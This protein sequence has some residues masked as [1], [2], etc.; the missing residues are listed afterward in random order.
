MQLSAQLESTALAMVIIQSQSQSW[1]HVLQYYLPIIMA[2]CTA[3][4][5]VLPIA[6]IVRR[7]KLQYYLYYPLHSLHPLLGGETAVLSVLP[8]APIAPIARRGNQVH[9]KDKMCTSSKRAWHLTC[10]GEEPHALVRRPIAGHTKPHIST[11]ITDPRT[12]VQ[13]NSIK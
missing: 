2:T 3:I 9:R 8:I 10:M 4:L 6:P 1:H 11:N 12:Q 7:G 5:S 13:G